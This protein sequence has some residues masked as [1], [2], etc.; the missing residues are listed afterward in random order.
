M[1]SARRAGRNLWRE[2]I[3]DAALILLS[4]EQLSS[5]PFDRLLQNHT[6][7]SRLC[8][9][10][11]DEVHLVQDWGDPFFREAFRHIALVH[12]RMPR[13]TTLIG[14]TATLL[15]GQET[16]ELLETLGLKP[17]NFFFQRRSNIRHDVKDIYRVLRHGLSG[18]SFPDLDW[19]VEGSRKTLIYCGSFS[20]CFRLRVYFHYKSPSTV[21]RLYNSLCFSSYNIKS[22]SLFVADLSTQ[23]IIATD[24]LVVGIDFPNVE[25]VVDV[26]CRHPN[27]GKQR[28]GRTGRAGGNVKDPR[29]ITYVTK[30]TME[31]AKK[32]VE[33]YKPSDHGGK[34]VYQG[35]HIG[36]AQLLVSSCYSECE[37]L[38]YDNPPSDPPCFCESCRNLPSPQSTICL[39]SGCHPEL[40]L[41]PLH[42]TNQAQTTIPMELRL[43]EQMMALGTVRLHEFRRQLWNENRRMLGHLPPV[44]II[45]DNRI[46]TL[47]DN[48]GRLKN[49]QDLSP[50]IND[51]HI[52]SPHEAHLFSIISELRTSFDLLPHPKR[53]KAITFEDSSAYSTFWTNFQRPL[54]TLPTPNQSTV[55]LTPS[56]RVFQEENQ[57]NVQLSPRKVRQSKVVLCCCSF[58][59]LMLIPFASVTRKIIKYLDTISVYIA[60]H[61]SSKYPQVLRLHHHQFHVQ[62]QTPDLRHLFE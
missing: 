20:L 29:G 18:W 21:I 62:I 17:G 8:A 56:K 3:E 5:Q 48:F 27:L 39:C 2:C 33:K 44:A 9:L 43:T 52:L 26:D 45:S 59:F 25:D 60:N 36:M 23:I 15:A 53:K 40:P 55:P 61:C 38:L 42:R 46:K 34:W 10:G 7:S 31:K 32:M 30:A 13:R 51:L 11:I 41:P 22:R 35:L 24:S 1:I 16:Q 54:Q 19:I 49:I 4:P 50:Y 47:L 28:K 12:A 58:H 57:T 6:F 37:N 14:L